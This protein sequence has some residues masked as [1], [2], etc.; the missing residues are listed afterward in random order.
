M[1]KQQTLSWLRDDTQ[2]VSKTGNTTTHSQR[3]SPTYTPDTE[4][5]PT[6][7]NPNPGI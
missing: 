1:T 5:H 2:W 6:Y 7:N 3:T 4:W